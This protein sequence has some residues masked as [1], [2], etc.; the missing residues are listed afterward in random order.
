MGEPARVMTHEPTPGRGAGPFD[1]GDHAAYRR[2]RAWKLA[3]H[4]ARVEDLVVEI[5]DPRA[6]AAAE[7]AALLDRIG[8]A[9]MALYRSPVREEDR[10]LPRRLGAQLGLHRLDAH[11][12]AD[13]DGISSIAV[14][15]PA[16]AP[17]TAAERGAFIPYTDRAIRW[18]TDGYYHPEGRRIRG[19]ILHCVR[20]AASG[21]V[22]RLLDH[23]MAYIALRDA[24]PAHVHALMQPD[25]MTI[26]A[27]EGD[28]GVAR[29]AQAGPVFSVDPRDGSLHLRYTART[30]SIEWKDDAATRD[31]V[32]SLEDLLAS[33]A[34]GMFTVRMDAG[35]GLVGHNV[36][37]DR[38]AFADDPAH[39]RLLYRARFL[40][41][42]QGLPAPPC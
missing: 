23:E 24:S 16:A 36:L 21:G 5:A 37:H 22:N 1:L 4:P 35:M 2:W 26:P 12:L 38:S 30:R 31:A 25:A 17:R 41:R 14:H 20:P 15:D 13:E 33:D 34:R 10:A 8:R 42:V 3:C 19:M 18:H 32:R 28:S 27:R 7:R 9:N 29:A 39:P 6:L 11:W 40:D